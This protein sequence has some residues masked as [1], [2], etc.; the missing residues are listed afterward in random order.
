VVTLARGAERSRNCETVV[1]EIN[2]LHAEGINEAVLSGVHLGGYGSDIGSDL[3]SLVETVLQRTEIPRL[4]LGAVEPWDLPAD[5]WGLFDNPRMLPHLHLPLQSGSD[6]ILRMMARRCKRAEFQR[7]VESARAA[8]PD[9]NLSTD[10]IVGFP[11]EREEEWQQTLAFSEQIGF[12]HMHI[13]A[14]SPRDGTRAATLP[15]PVPREVIRARSQQLHELGRRMKRELLARQLGRIYPVLFEGGAHAEG[16]AGGYTP[17]FLRTEVRLPPGA[18]SLC[19]EIHAVRITA[20][21]DDG[22]N[23]IGELTPGPTQ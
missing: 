11:G 6:R 16:A 3:T 4:R 8:V 2:R 10:I 13:F 15:D 20:V 23:L 12:G 7:L 1:D 9:L 19:N 21:A 17:N 14:Y 5:F 22:E 18:P